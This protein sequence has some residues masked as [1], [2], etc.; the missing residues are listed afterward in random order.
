M[1]GYFKAWISDLEPRA[2]RGW[3]VAVYLGR[4]KNLFVCDSCGKDIEF[5]SEYIYSFKDGLKILHN[6]QECTVDGWLT[7]EN[8]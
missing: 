7:N 5:R 3:G 6:T 4:L 8:P 1:S 2:P